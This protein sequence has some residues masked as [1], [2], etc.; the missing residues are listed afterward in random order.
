MDIKFLE[1]FL[2]LAESGNF[3]KAAAERNVTQPAFSRRIKS[4]EIAVG[5][6]LID[7]SNYPTSL[8]PAGEAFRKSASDIV[9]RF[10]TAIEN[11]RAEK[12]RDYATI[13]F[14]VSRSL[15]ISYMPNWFGAITKHV[16]SFHLQVHTDTVHDCM[17][18]LVEGDCHFMACFAHPAVPVPTSPKDYPCRKVG[19]ATLLPVAKASPE[20]RPWFMFPGTETDPVPCLDYG[21]DT[22]VGKV[23]EQ[24]LRERDEQLFTETVYE[25]DIPEALKEMAIAGHGMAFV[26]QRIVRKELADGTLA[27]AGDESYTVP[28]EVRMYGRGGFSPEVLAILETVC[29]MEE[30]LDQAADAS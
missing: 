9:Q 22:Y 20:G 4:L 11:A 30:L 10:Y 28:L 16:E 27:L 8:T 24:V 21:P 14:A 2:Q 3:S 7:R 25:G 13:K 15:A 18:A 26:P 5:V 12:A 1:D 17:H 6:P 19:S 23:L 29:E